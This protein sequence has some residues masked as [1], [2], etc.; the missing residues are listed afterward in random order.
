MGELGPRHV[1]DTRLAFRS[2]LVAPLVALATPGSAGVGDLLVA[3][4]RIILNGGR[5]TEIILNNIGEE[6]ATYRISV[7]VKRMRAD[8]TFEDVGRAQCPRK[9][10]ART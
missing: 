10:R 1:T 3:P 9:D 5:G 6:T 8:G 2:A 4:T 7:E